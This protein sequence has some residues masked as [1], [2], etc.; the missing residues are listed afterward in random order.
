MTHIRRLSF[1]AISNGPGE[2]SLRHCGKAVLQ[3]MHLLLNGCENGLGGC[4]QKSLVTHPESGCTS[5]EDDKPKLLN[6]GDTRMDSS[7]EIIKQLIG[8][9]GALHDK[10]SAK[11]DTQDFLAD[12]ATDA[13]FTKC[14]LRLPKLH[15]TESST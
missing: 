3:Q 14:T 11:R 9:G 4:I 6:Q 8:S 2:C 1:D 7:F 12:N 10:P 15:D 5:A 13:D